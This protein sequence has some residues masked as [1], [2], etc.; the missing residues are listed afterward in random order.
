MTIEFFTGFEGASSIKPF[1]DYTYNVDGWS[2][3]MDINNTQGFNSSKCMRVYLYNGNM[4]N[5]Y[6]YVYKNLSEA[7]TKVV[8][9]HVKGLGSNEKSGTTNGGK[10]SLVSF[11]CVDGSYIRVVCISQY[12]YCYYNSTL[13]GQSTKIVDDNIHHLEIKVYSHASLGS[14]QIKK[15][16]ELIID[17]SNLNTGGSLLN[18]LYFG[19]CSKTTHYIDNIFVA[20]DFQGEIYS[21]LLQPASD[22]TV[23]FTPLSGTDNYAMIQSDDGDTSYV[24]SNTPG[25]KD[26]YN[27]DELS[28]NLVPVCISILG[29][30][31]KDGT[32]P[33][34]MTSLIEQD[35]TEYEGNEEYLLENDY[36]STGAGPIMHE[37][38]NTAPDGSSWTRNNL[39]ALKIGFKIV[40]EISS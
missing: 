7:S 26:L 29:I 16:G 33:V 10:Y 18:K 15:D 13:L 23:E 14:V 11:Q 12:L 6:G 35:A 25:H 8:G 2:A 40:D 30:M 19:T 34:K 20:D 38:W 3:Y 27:Y 17:I 24:E 22:D 28:A 21:E 5:Y 32:G 37:V 1:F 39:N 36:P 9:F 31:K 4:S